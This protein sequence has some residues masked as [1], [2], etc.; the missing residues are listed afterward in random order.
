ML[1]E[2]ITEKVVLLS[3][4]DLL[5]LMEVIVASLKEKQ[6]YEQQGYLTK[7]RQSK[8]IGCF[9]GDPNLAANSE[10]NFQKIMDEKYG[11]R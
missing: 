5:S 4:S 6:N 7:L 11:S 8:F 1:L 3:P 9:D 10:A 2:E